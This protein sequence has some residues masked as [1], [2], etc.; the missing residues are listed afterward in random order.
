MKLQQKL[1]TEELTNKQLLS[2]YYNQKLGS[3]I[4]NIVTQEIHKRSLS[5]DK[6]DSMENKFEIDPVGIFQPLLTWQKILIIIFPISPYILFWDIYGGNV[7]KV[8]GHC[9]YSIIG[10]LVWSVI[11]TGYLILNKEKT[12]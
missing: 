1:D 11:L 10:F 4:K 2:L 9:K 8:E 6:L 12:A 7:K 3:E 5:L